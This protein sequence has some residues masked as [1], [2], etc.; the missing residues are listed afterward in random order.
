MPVCL[1]TLPRSLMTPA[2]LLA[3]GERLPVTERDVVVVGGGQAALAGKTLHDMGYT[4]VANAGGFP[5]WKEKGGPTE[6]G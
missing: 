2:C 5:A 3:P 6:D 1:H 4:N